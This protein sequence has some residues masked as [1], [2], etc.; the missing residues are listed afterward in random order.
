MI[1]G[2]SVDRSVVVKNYN[3][4]CAFESLG[5]RHES[6]NQNY[7]GDLDMECQKGGLDLVLSQPVEKLFKKLFYGKTEL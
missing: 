3:R 5:T 1:H 6:A 2:V 7:F 4:S